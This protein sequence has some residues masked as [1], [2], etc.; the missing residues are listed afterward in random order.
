MRGLEKDGG[1]LPLC[2]GAKLALALTSFDRQEPAEAK[3]LCFE[4]ATDQRGK[5]RR[6]TWHDREWQ[7]A[8]DT[9]AN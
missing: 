6:G 5:N 1:L 3:F 2:S 7:F 8:L 9:F 4:A